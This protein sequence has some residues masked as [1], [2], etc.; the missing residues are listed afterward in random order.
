MAH[1]LREMELYARFIGQGQYL[2]VSD[3]HLNGHPIFME[4]LH[5]GPGPMEALDI[6]LKNNPAFAS[7]R[8]REKYGLTFNPRGFLKRER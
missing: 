4:P 8:N 2:I 1:V 5:R 6:F 7:D 3:T